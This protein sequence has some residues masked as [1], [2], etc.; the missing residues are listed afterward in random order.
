MYITQVKPKHSQKAL[1]VMK[2]VCVICE[3]VDIHPCYLSRFQFKQHIIYQLCCQTLHV[4]VFSIR[5]GREGKGANHS[6]LSKEKGG[7]RFEAGDHLLFT[8][9]PLALCH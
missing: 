8:S 3:C 4:I 1:K 6:L 9:T 5:P 7:T 2:W